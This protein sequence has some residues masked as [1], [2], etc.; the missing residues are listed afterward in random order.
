MTEE[1]FLLVNESF[2]LLTDNYTVYRVSQEKWTKLRDSVPYVELYRYNPKHLYPNF[3]VS[4][5]IFQ[6]NNG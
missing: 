4:P 2:C 1:P 3:I 6:F 5:C